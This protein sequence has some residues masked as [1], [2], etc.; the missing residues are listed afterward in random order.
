[1]TP[2]DG[3]QQTLET[4][5]IVIATGSE[6]AALPGIA[7]DEKTHRLLHRRAVAA[8]VPKRLVVIGAGVIGLELGSVW[9]RLGARGDGGRD[10]DRILPGLDGEVARQF[11]RILEKQGIVSS[12]HQG[13]GRREERHGAA[14]SRSSRRKAATAETLDCDVVLVAIG[15]VPYTQGLGLDEVGV[16]PT[17]AG[18]SSSI[19]H[20]ATNVPAST[21]S[22][23]SSPGRCWPT[24][25][26]T[27]ASPSPRSWPGRPA[28]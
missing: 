25:P 28:T 2:I 27:K 6:V 7:I 16:E 4:K 17:S 5:A 3:E 12:S 26:R 20:F 18:A 23:M 13:H 10:L 11:Q 1:M 8:K 22:A 9:R 14:A 19:A 24:R 21:P 15:R